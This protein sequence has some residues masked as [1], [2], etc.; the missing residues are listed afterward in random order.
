[1]QARGFLNYRFKYCWPK[2]I[3]CTC[4][5]NELKRDIKKKL[6]EPSSGPRKNLGGHGPPRPPLRI[7]TVGPDLENKNQPVHASTLLRGA[8]FFQL[9]QRW[10]FIIPLSTVK[11]LKKCCSMHPNILP[12]YLFIVFICLHQ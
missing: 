1:M 4:L 8:V 3:Y 7:A 2:V 5:P 10:K 11:K 6:G 12:I 9:F